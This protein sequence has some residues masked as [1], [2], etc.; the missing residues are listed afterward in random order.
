MARAI[1]LYA[2]FMSGFD[3]AGIDREFFALTEVK[4]SFICSNLGYGD[5]SGLF[6]RS[7]RFAFEAMAKII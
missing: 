7:P 5:P 3:N 4:S 1:G 2:G 6:A